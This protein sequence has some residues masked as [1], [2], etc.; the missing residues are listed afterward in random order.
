MLYAWAFAL[1]GPVAAS[2]LNWTC[3]LLLL[4]ATALLAKPL[5]G[6]HYAWLAGLLPLASPGLRYQ[7]TIPLADLPLAMF[8]AFALAAWWRGM[9]EQTS[10]RWLVVAGVSWGAASATNAA[11]VAL[12]AAVALVWCHEVSRSHERRYRDLCERGGIVLGVAALVAIPWWT[13]TLAHGGSLAPATP[14]AADWRQLGPLFFALTPGLLL[15]RRLR[16]MHAIGSLALCITATS[17]LIAPQSRVYLMLLPLL[18]ILGT[19]VLMEL[20]RYPRVPRLAVALLLFIICVAPLPPSLHAL[21][22]Q[23]P[24]VTGW[25]PRDEFLRRH[26]PNYAAAQVAN[27]VIQPDALLASNDPSLLYFGCRT[28][29]LAGNDSANSIAQLKASGVTHVLWRHEGAKNPEPKPTEITD[30]S[31]PLT[32]Y[33]ALPDGEKTACQYELRLLLRR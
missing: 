15:T 19:W 24:V 25:Q 16:G 9:V 18:A 29:Y 14:Q 12:L 31:L 32:S 5:V 7:M 21:A 10:N 8:S 17:W 23:L 2:L 28:Q 13:F 3:G 6:S 26:V 22:E 33:S 27:R 20:A 4:A 30:D 1:D 11:A